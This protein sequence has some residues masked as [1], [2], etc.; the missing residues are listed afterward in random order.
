MD[1][2]TIHGRFAA[3]ARRTPEAVALAGA[4][5][6]VR[7]RELDAASDG[8]AAWLGEQGLR[9]GV[10]VGVLLPRSPELV[11]VLL[12]VLKAGAAYSVLS[13]DWPDARIRALCRRLG[14]PLVL[15]DAAVAPPG[16]P[17]VVLPDGGLPGW[18]ALADGAPETPVDERSAAQVFFTSGSSGEPKASVSPHG[19]LT[20]LVRDCGFL[21]LDAGTVMPL[22]APASWDAFALEL[23]GPLL[24][25]GVA[26]LPDG[27]HLDPA[28]LRRAVTRHGVNT[29]WLGAALFNVVVEEDLGAFAGLRHLV[30]GGE[31][32]S[33]QHVR[34]FLRAHPDATLT[35]GYG[36]V[37]CTV[38]VTTHRI[39]P[40]DCDA[41][42]GIPLGRPVNDTEVHVLS[43]DGES[44][45]AGS[46]GEICVGGPRLGLGYLDDSAATDERFVVRTV[47][48]RPRRLYRTGDLGHLSPTGILH[49]VGRLDRQVK[50]R[51]HRIAPEEIEAALDAVPG[52]ARA[53]V[54]PVETGTGT[55]LVACYTADPAPGPDERIVR[56]RLARRLPAHL[57]PHRVRRLPALPMLPNGKLDRAALAAATT[58]GP[59]VP[60]GATATLDATAARASAGNLD[61]VAAALRAV[62]GGHTPDPDDDLVEA[63][64]TSLDLIR[65][66]TRLGQRLGR[67]VPVS[68]LLRRPT[69]TAIAAWLDDASPSGRAPDADP[70]GPGAVPLLPMQA[71]F[72]L[73]DE[74][75]GDAVAHCAL[76]W[77][78]AG[79]FDERAFAAAVADL[80]DRHEAL[81]ARYSLAEAAAYPTGA[82][83]DPPVRRLPPTP[84]EPSAL[85]VVTAAVDRPLRPEAGEV[86]RAVLVTN[87]ATPRTL[88]AF[89]VHHVAW[90]VEA[91]RVAVAELAAGYAARLA[92]DRARLPPAPT[93]AGTVRRYRERL[94]VVPLDEQRRFWQRELAD[95]PELPLD[96]S[97]PM[98]D[99]GPVRTRDVP[100]G[101]ELLAGVDELAR[102][103]GGTR[104]A[105]LLAGFAAAVARVTGS[106]DFGVGVP[107]TKRGD[108][109][110]D[111][112]VTCL[113]DTVCVRLRPGPATAAEQAR[114]T[115]LALRRAFLAQDVTID[116]VVRLSRP[117]A[118][119]SGPRYRLMFTV[120]PHDVPELPLPGC[121]TVGLRLDPSRSMTDLGCALWPTA[122]GGYRARFTYRPGLTAAGT[123]ISRA[124]A[125]WLTDAVG[126]D[127]ARGPGPAAPVATRP[128]CGP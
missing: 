119:A 70:A 102:R 118:T 65:V 126:A 35:N 47:D 85:R 87:A 4:A 56:D 128:A 6:T 8:V 111:R 107:V 75:V 97:S 108:E 52:V 12:G 120:Q 55:E 92:G 94:G 37:E 40:A 91:E 7:Y 19:A 67:P 57:V 49:Y 100:I 74:L 103:V 88:V 79:P 86:C 33:P 58:A 42:G 110:L 123:E 105:V 18:A 114:D 101:P 2:L 13:R 41:P 96:G 76:A 106:R 82:T 17:P 22:G 64:A 122:D 77:W 109:L 11:A 84:D 48:G 78:V 1:P 14:G 81:R 66:C 5:G 27:P 90:D 98:D 60:P 15:T 117:S 24:A 43:P 44:C 71:G 112:A 69:V 73:A 38:F 54:V 29:A 62:L 39:T 61:A 83:S 51:G 3:Q 53:A 113:I 9:P 99:D 124:M 10:A 93:L 30:I 21:P 68:Q 125:V 127:P 31:R 45:P 121:R 36:P 80:V 115:H 95:L 25:G 59:T 20:R 16:A 89:V 26:V 72:L 34:R 28:T 63:G 32:L 116:E 104:L 46:T 23:W 50:V